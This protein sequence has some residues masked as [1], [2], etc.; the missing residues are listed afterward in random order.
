MKKY[1]YA[2]SFPKAEALRRAGY[3]SQDILDHVIKILLYRTIRPDDID[4][5]INEISSWLKDVDSLTVKP[6]SRPLKESDVRDTTFACM[7]DELSDYLFS[8]KMFQTDNKRGKF[9]YEDKEPYPYVEPDSATASDLM[10]ICYSI[11][12]Q[13]LPLIC[14]KDRHSRQEFVE[15]LNSIFNNNI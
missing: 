14:S 7:G 2:M 9:N 11:I 15:L 4:H 12:E 13:T 3:Y 10:D 8:L 5:W 6:N 1:I